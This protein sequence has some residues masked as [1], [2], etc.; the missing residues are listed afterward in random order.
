[1]KKLF[2][3]LGREINDSSPVFLNKGASEN[4]HAWLNFNEEEGQLAVD[5]YQTDDD[6]IVK[7]TIAG[8]ASKDIEISLID[9]MLTIRGRRELD[10]EV[11]SD[12]YLY[13]ECYWGKFSRSIMLPVEVRGDKV[14][15]SLH[16]GVLTVVLPKAKRSKHT[17]IR[18]KE[19]KDR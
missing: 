3:M 11:A 18:V 19:A 12:A 10:E 13:R 7:S 5:I 17:S 1:M 8:A 2:R 6:L 14:S 15:A 16:N 4:E 9:D